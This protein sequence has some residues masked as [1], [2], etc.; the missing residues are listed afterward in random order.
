MPDVSS[1][2]FVVFL[3]DRKYRNQHEGIVFSNLQDAQVFVAEELREY[4]NY[5]VV[6]GSFMEENQVKERYMSAV[7]TFGFKGDKK[8]PSQLDLF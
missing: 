5:R 2:R 1:L 6:I 7:Q 4:P 8:R 3:L